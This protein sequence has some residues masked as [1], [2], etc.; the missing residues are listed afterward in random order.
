ML[1]PYFARDNSKKR[2]NSGIY[3]RIWPNDGGTSVI[4]IV[5]HGTIKCIRVIE[6][7]LAITRYFD[8]PRI[9]R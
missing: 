1:R 7:T 6:F 4:R 5:S 8:A 2:K 9:V 3:I